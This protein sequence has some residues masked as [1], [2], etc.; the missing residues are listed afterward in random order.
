MPGDRDE[1]TPPTRKSPPSRNREP[2]RDPPPPTGAFRKLPGIP[3][4][5]TDHPRSLLYRR[6]GMLAVADG[7][8]LVAYELDRHDG[9]WR[10]RPA[11][12]TKVKGTIRELAALEGG[13]LA[14]AV[15]SRD[16]DRL[17]VAHEDHLGELAELPARAGAMAVAGRTLM[18]SL[19]AGAGTEAQV[20]GYDWTSGTRRLSWPV[21]SADLHLSV[22]PDAS[23]VVATDRTTGR[24]HGIPT[25]RDCDRGVALPPDD[26]PTPGGD[27]PRELDPDRRGYNGCGCGCRCGPLRP[28]PPGPGREPPDSTVP[29]PDPGRPD[30]GRPDPETPRPRP[31]GPGSITLPE[32]CGKVVTVG[33]RLRRVPCTP[34]E[35]ECDARVDFPVATLTRAGR[36]LLARAPSDRRMA[37]L[38][39]STFRVVNQRALPSE[40]VLMATAP[41][42]ERLVAFNGRSGS[43]EV[44]EL[45]TLPATL[46]PLEL[47]G[48]TTEPDEITFV[49]RNRLQISR[50]TQATQGERRVLMIPVIDNGQSWNEVNVDKVGLFADQEMFDEF[51]AYYTE[52]SY[53]A[54]E[55]S[56][57]FLG[58]TRWA[59]AQPVELPRPM[60]SYFHPAFEPGGM[61]ARQDLGPGTHD[62]FLDGS[63]SLDLVLDPIEGSTTEV[64]VPTFALGGTRDYD[65]FPTLSF[66]GSETAALVETLGDG[67]VFNLSVSFPSQSF[68]FTEG[69]HAARLTE[70]ADYLLEALQDAED[71]AGVPGGGQRI[72]SVECR[73][74]R[75]DDQDFGSLHVN[76]R[77]S[78]SGDGKGR[79][80][81]TGQTGLDIIGFDDVLRGEFS[82]PG[83]ESDL[84]AY[85]ERALEDGQ[86]DAGMELSNLQV[87]S[88]EADHSGTTLTIDFLFT[89]EY[90]GKEA[91][92]RR[93]GTP[94]GLD[95]MGFDDAEPLE[96]SDTNKDDAN[97]LR[98]SQ[99][100]L[101]DVM[102]AVIDHIG[103]P[104]SVGDLDVYSSI[105]LAFILPAPSGLS[106]PAWSTS[107]PD[108]AGLRMFAR[109]KTARY[110]PDHDIQL[111]SRFIGTLLGDV[112]ENGTAIHEIGHSLDYSDQYYEE[113]NRDDLLYLG[114][115]DLMDDSDT[116]SHVGAYHKIFSG[117][118][119]D[120]RVRKVPRPE[121]TGPITREAL[122]VPVEYWDDGMEAAVQAAFPATAPG[123]YQ[124]LRIDLGGDGVQYG[125]IEARQEGIG[126]SKSLP[127]Q[128]ALLVTNCL[129]PQDDTRYAENGKFR[130]QVHRLNGHT[131]LTAV[132]DAFNLAAAPALP[133]KGVSVEIVGEA[134][135]SRPYGLVHVFHV[136]VVVEQADYIDL[137]FT[138]NVPDWQS[139][140]LWVDYRDDND[141]RDEPR[142]YPVGEP[143]DQGEDVRP[144][145]DHFVVA[146]VWNKGKG[147]IPAENV[148]VRLEM[149][150]P[151]GAG[152]HDFAFQSSVILPSVADGDWEP[153]VFRWTAPEGTDHLCL[154]AVIEDWEVPVDSS[155]EALA[156]GD[157]WVSNNHA[158]QNV[159]EFIS[160]SGSPFEPVEFQ[161]SVSNTGP[162]TERAILEPE[163]LPP[164]VRL[165]VAPRRRVIEPGATALF[166]CT[167]TLD[168][169][170]VRA[171]CENDRT[172]MLYAYRETPHALVR[173]SGCK[174]VIKPRTRSTTT[175][176]GMWSHDALK[177]HGTVTPAPAG[178]E[179]RL[180]L[181][182]EGSSVPQWVPV[183][184]EAGGSFQLQETFDFPAGTELRARAFFDGDRQLAPS[185][186]DE[187]VRSNA[188]V[189]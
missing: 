40:G 35:P 124:A 163:F 3:K 131:D 34:E 12:R 184:L 90:G 178:G 127:A 96:A 41:D 18:V 108:S 110:K 118:I 66:T 46:P 99:E 77:M 165:R 4:P 10:A 130:R 5:E 83:D 27:V 33:G 70:L 125:L 107:G 157:L 186:S 51:R 168:E 104:G 100:M 9:G 52:V 82:I 138:D 179:V 103:G 91:E 15:R 1:E 166:R 44:L 175:L 7:P 21:Q 58:Y 116:K 182:F 16:G 128:P 37:V 120:S 151:G 49:G 117:W 177:L 122:L 78:E 28:V 59:P 181:L 164:G 6:G 149:K 132:G 43:W 134:D 156:S 133:A 17:F 97:A 8:L 188:I 169:Q 113:V 135:V 57:D 14:L 26:R 105:F 22:A 140:D 147:G 154:R 123:V 183:P 87:G 111:E 30:P 102:T 180:R 62:L 98:D 146:R 101:D 38:D 81:L 106:T 74:V 20:V 56:F 55:M 84:A 145:E 45:D 172:F 60:R 11:W 141:D 2:P 89:D 153:A 75:R 23:F 95:E 86:T 171:G 148:R 47:G 63:E 48:L 142:L 72:D 167:V 24:V 13:R 173:W 162:V 73:R 29:L 119:P 121:P 71:V 32:P 112:A 80:R 69:N 170:T 174:Y 65:A 79:L 25:S 185:T 39:A 139:P 152:D 126:F 88:V 143:L 31:C 129:D 189:G 85:W 94:S 19:E 54:L 176:N 109:S 93:D 68:A 42:S 160:A 159:F 158:Q 36:F 61:R 92:I 161:F 155:G 144:G 67:S 53:G 137:T 50:S 76:V 114:A 150:D 187:I 64:A 136:Q 115:W